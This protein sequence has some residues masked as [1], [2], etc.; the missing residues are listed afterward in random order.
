MTDVPSDQSATP[1]F[2]C[3]G[4][5][6]S[7]ALPQSLDATFMTCPYCGRKS[8]IPEHIF[9]DRKKRSGKLRKAA[10]KAKDKANKAARLES[11]RKSRFRNRLIALFV[12][13]L[14][15]G[16]VAYVTW[17][18]RDTRPTDPQY[19]GLNHLNGTMATL[20]QA[21][22]EYVVMEPVMSEGEST[23]SVNMH[24]GGDCV[25]V[26]AATG[27]ATNTLTMS[28]TTPFGSPVPAPAP[29]YLVRIAHCPQEEG[30][31]PVTI[32]AAEEYYYHVAV[33]GCPRS[34][35]NPP[36]TTTR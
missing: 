12:G 2:V 35:Y 25:E 28:M 16:L 5:R 15:T 10:K 13:L 14:F 30:S 8:P 11:E 26:I 6:G 7:L 18:S 31:F 21:G 4:C 1:S 3:E 23:Y 9:K 20:R 24:S 34:V 17:A 29:S 19:T 22:C 27:V 32:T 33:V 36:P